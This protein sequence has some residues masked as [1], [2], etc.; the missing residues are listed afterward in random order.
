MGPVAAT[1]GR[2]ELLSPAGAEPLEALGVR[3]EFCP[4][5]APSELWVYNISP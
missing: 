2:E 4:R 3:S 5:G 1:S